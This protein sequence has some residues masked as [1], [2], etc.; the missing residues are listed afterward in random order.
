MAALVAMVIEPTAIDAVE[1]TGALES[2]RQLIDEDKTVEQLPELFAFGL[3]ADFD[4]PQIVAMSAG[5]TVVFRDSRILQR[6]N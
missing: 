2:L 1:V 3:L 6:P 5:R 4:V